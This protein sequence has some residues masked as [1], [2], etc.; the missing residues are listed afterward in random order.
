MCDVPPR[1]AFRPEQLA[2]K[3]SIVLDRKLFTTLDRVSNKPD[4][5]PDDVAIQEELL[6][7]VTDIIAASGTAAV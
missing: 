4:G 6:L 3:L 1:D 2:E 7:G 5:D